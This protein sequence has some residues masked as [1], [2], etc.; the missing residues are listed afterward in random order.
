MAST[1]KPGNKAPDQV[2][3]IPAEITYAFF[4][5]LEAMAEYNSM[6]RAVDGPLMSKA[7]RAQE[8]T[9]QWFQDNPIG[10]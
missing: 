9:Y 3:M 1:K 5:L 8:E 6:T 7:L 10:G 4:R 2:L